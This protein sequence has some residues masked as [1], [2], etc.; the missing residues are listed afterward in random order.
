MSPLSK[1][2]NTENASLFKLVKDSNSNRAN[3]LKIKKTI[4]IIGDSSSLNQVNGKTVPP[5][6]RR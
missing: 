2:T 1:I 4:A 6:N 3:D 5:E